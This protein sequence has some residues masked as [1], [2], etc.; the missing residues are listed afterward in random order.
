MPLYVNT[1]RANGKTHAITIP[2]GVLR[3]LHWKRG[4]VLL[5]EVSATNTLI[6]HPENAIQ[7]FLRMRAKSLNDDYGTEHTVNQK[8]TALAG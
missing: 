2:P 8:D 3:A 1:L 4:D 5:L 7:D 6:I